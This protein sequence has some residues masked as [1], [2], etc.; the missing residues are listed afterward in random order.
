MLQKSNFLAFL[1]L[2]LARS[3]GRLPWGAEGLRLIY[4]YDP[5]R[6][7][8]PCPSVLQ[9]EPSMAKSWYR[10]VGTF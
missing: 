7:Q 3:Y 10:S 1:W 5:P 9:A 8:V 6:A 2:C 4:R